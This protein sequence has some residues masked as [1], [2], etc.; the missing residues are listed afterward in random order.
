MPADPTLVA[1]PV[2][3]RDWLPALQGLL[4]PL[5]PRRL[6][7]L[8]GLV[9]PSR[10]QWIDRMP[11]DVVVEADGGTLQA[12]DSG[13]LFP[14]EKR[15]AQPLLLFMVTDRAEAAP[16]LL[17]NA[18]ATLCR[19]AWRLRQGEHGDGDDDARALGEAIHGLRNGLNSVLMSA[20]VITTCADLL[21]ERLQPIAREI[22]AAAH[23]S[24]DR[25]HKL[26]ALIEPGR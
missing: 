1:D 5:E 6:V 26:T 18:A 13:W 16:D 9:M 10:L 2:A 11:D 15:G 14:L 8:R 19:C 3:L 17:M 12:D 24:V 20:A 23:R 22:E 25:L 21:P 7:L 4:A